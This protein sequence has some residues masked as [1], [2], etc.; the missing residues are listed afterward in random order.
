L[1]HPHAR[2]LKT[3]HR[4]LQRIL[5]PSASSHLPD[6]CRTPLWGSTLKSQQH[7]LW[8]LLFRRSC[9]KRIY[10]IY[11]TILGKYPSRRKCQVIW[12]SCNKKHTALILPKSSLR[13]TWCSQ[14]CHISTNSREIYLRNIPN[15]PNY[16]NRCESCIDT[17]I[18]YSPPE[19]QW[20]HPRWETTINGSRNSHGSSNV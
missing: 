17:H 5:I 11:A 2:R 3:N 19:R 6:T 18:T 12:V 20:R 9:M 8:R 13:S 14:N 7:S 16:Y 4:A 1:T 15:T 10:P